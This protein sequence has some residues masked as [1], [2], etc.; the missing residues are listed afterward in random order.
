MPDGP[1]W[2]KFNTV[3]ANQFCDSHKMKYGYN[4]GGTPTR[5]DQTSGNV[6]PEILPNL[7]L[8]LLIETFFNTL[9]LISM[10]SEA[11]NWIDNIIYCVRCIT[12]PDGLYN[13][14]SLY[15]ENSM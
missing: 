9:S 11:L 3:F 1:R 7:H 14:I 2:W 8:K 5:H 12:F 10:K 4:Y 13:E 6:M 15:I